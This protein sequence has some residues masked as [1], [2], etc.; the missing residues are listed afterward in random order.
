MAGRREFLFA[1]LC[2]ALARGSTP[3]K[4]GHRQ[5]SLTKQP[6]PE[7]FDLARRIPGLTGVEL[8]VQFQKTT[9]WDRETV[10][11]YRNGARSTGLAIPSLAGIWTGGA[12]LV[13]PP[14]AEDAIRRSIQ[15]A[16]ALQ[17]RVVLVAAFS[18]NCPQ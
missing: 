8:Q 9:L 1:S 10:L 18:K 3:L 14:V 5:A 12:S 2:A 6:G 13:Q 11:A 4:I 17:A 16:D 7:V 15:A